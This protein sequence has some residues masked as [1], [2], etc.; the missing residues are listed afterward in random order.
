M[1]PACQALVIGETTL[2]RW[3]LPYEPEFL[4]QIAWSK[5]M[6]MEQQL[7]FGLQK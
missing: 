4:N 1:P 6:I 7:F 2:R 3:I 5:V